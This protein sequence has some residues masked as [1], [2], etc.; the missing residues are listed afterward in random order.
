MITPA[1][2][3]ATHQHWQQMREEAQQLTQGGG[4]LSERA[5]AASLRFLVE[6]SQREFLGATS[7]TVFIGRC[8]E[9]TSG[10]RT[11]SERSISTLKE[12]PREQDVRWQERLGRMQGALTALQ[13]YEVFLVLL[14]R[15]A[16]NENS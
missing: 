6:R 15:Q 11:N 10:L 13:D 1:I 12:Q 7:D 5:R 14:L 3:Q 9:L 2:E 8:L 4:T 16:R